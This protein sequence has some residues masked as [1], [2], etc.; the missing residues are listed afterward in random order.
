MKRAYAKTGLLVMAAMVVG[1]LLS[2]AIGAS[3]IGRE[4]AV[5]V[6]L[7][8]G[9]EFQMTAAQLAAFGKTLFTAMWTSQ[10][11][12]GRPMT[13]GTGNHISDSTS[14]LIFPRNFNRISG[15]DTN[16]CSGCH[17]KPDI[18][19]GGDIVGN[20]FV[21]GQR[22]DF[23]T[24]D[25]LDPVPTRGGVDEV[26]KPVFL[27]TIADSRKTIGMFG[28]GYLEMVAR[29]MT[30]D[31]QSIRDNTPLGA[32]QALVSKGVSFGMITHNTDGTWDT[33]KVVGLA[34]PATATSATKAPDLII[35]PY[36]QASNVISVRQFT[37]NAFNHH[38]GIQSEERFGIG[39]DP[40]G[41]G[42]VNELTRADVTAATIFQITLPVPGR[43]IPNDPDI[44][45]AIK[46]GARKFREIGCADCHLPSLPLDKEGWIYSEPNPYNPSGNLQVGQA[47]TIYVDLTDSNLPAPRLRPHED[48]VIQVPAFT[49]LRVHDIT[50]GPGDPNCEP[51]NMNRAAGTMGFFAGNCQFI[52]RKL[53]GIANQHSFGHHGLYTTMREATLA[54][55]GEA[56]G[57]RMAF[58]NLAPYDHD[59][60]IEFLKSLQ[61]LPAGTKCTVVDESMKC[62]HFPEIDP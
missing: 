43:V 62:I 20:V 32:S 45:H 12:A 30:A 61:I 28:S 40:D 25:S 19:G 13:K 44:R 2:N 49:D 11:G 55:A 57:S 54:H 52:T 59:S 1:I 23:A 34:P 29:Q 35:R 41:D 4:V 47:P 6:H 38:H 26:G 27:Q 39:A 31:L 48:G 24:F 5:P 50:S 46:N 21:L 17:N 42:F 9:Q 7:Q 8:D 22:F 53:W 18:G 60:V 15:P 10:E 33:S 36:H 14:P 58:Q 3:K 51:L 37:N 56:L 16:S